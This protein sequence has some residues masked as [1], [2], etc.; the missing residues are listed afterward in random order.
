MNVHSNNDF[1][2]GGANA[3]VQARGYKLLDVVY[4]EQTR[5]FIV[6]PA[7]RLGT[8]RGAFVFFAVFTQSIPGAC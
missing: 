6:C 5:T 2:A 8:R 1:A 7:S 4:Y 3:R